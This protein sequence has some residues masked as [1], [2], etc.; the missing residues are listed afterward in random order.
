MKQKPRPNPHIKPLGEEAAAFKKLQTAAER[1]K[2]T[3]DGVA[4]GMNF[5]E[6]EV[7][8]G[9]EWLLTKP[10]AWHV[11]FAQF[12]ACESRTEPASWAAMDDDMRF[13]LFKAAQIGWNMLAIKFA[14]HMLK[15]GQDNGKA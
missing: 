4:A 6:A 5:M 12:T 11:A 7:A 9:A 1:E 2:F 15:Q 3:K 8:A 14:E 13:L 10:M